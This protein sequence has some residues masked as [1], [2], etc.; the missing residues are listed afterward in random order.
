MIYSIG[1]RG[2]KLTIEVE[3]DKID[4]GLSQYIFQ[5]GLE[6]LLGRGRSKLGKPDTFVNPEAFEA[7]ALIIAEKQL[8][9]LYEGKTRVVGGAKRA[10]GADAAVQTEMLRIARI[11]A[12]EQVKTTRKDIK[13]SKVSA[14]EWTKAGKAYIEANPEHFRKTAEAN[15]AAARSGA[16]ATV[17]LSFIAEDPKKVAA[18]EKAKAGKKAKP[19]A[20]V[21]P[22]KAKAK[23]AQ[24]QARH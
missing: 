6:A 10:K 24:A 8:A 4:D 1:V 18:A 20:P 14:A 15:L 13:V 11:Y 7:E 17:D 21:V 2:T 5:K 3:S 9:A 22:A 16:E 23:P 12:K 19:S